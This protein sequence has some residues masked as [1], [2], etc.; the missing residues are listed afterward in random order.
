VLPPESAASH[1][2]CGAIVDAVD[3]A[4]A[5]AVLNSLVFDWALRLRTAG[6]NVSFTYVRPLTVPPADV[7]NSLPR[8]ETRLAWESGLDH[9]TADRGLWPDLWRLN[10]AVAEAYG[11]GPEEFEHILGAFPVFAR[12]RA[13]FTAYLREQV[14]AWKAGIAYYPAAEE[15]E[16][17]PLAAEAGAVSAPPGAAGAPPGGR[18]RGLRAKGN[19][20]SGPSE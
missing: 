3:A 15:R 7:V 12:K 20:R 1:K 11:L 10:R 17:G 8:F 16:V 18:R 5:A 13:A 14:Q 9:I 6:T 19:E 2:L 4:R